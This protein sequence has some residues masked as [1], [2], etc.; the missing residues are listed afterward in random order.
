LKKY[1]SSYWI[2]SAF[3]TFLQRFSL[4]LFGFV[5]FLILIRSLSKPQMGVW[6]FFLVVTTLFEST[7]SNLLKNAHIKFVGNS[8]REKTAIASSS[9]LVN[10]T[11][12]LL[13]ICFLFL[14]SGYL[15]N[16]LHTGKEL[17]DMLRWFTPGMIALVY[18][19]HFEA[20]A[21]SHLD[22]KSVFA[23]YFARQVLFFAL[24]VGHQLLKIPFSLVHLAIYQSVSI[25]LG[26]IVLFLF[27]KKHLLYVFNPT[28]AWIKKL[29]G[30]G[31]YI[32][33]IGITSSIFSN[34]DQLMIARFTSSK[35]MVASYNAATR[36]S[37]L[38]EI[39][40][41]S[42]AEILLPKVSQVDMSEGSNKVKYMYERMVGILLCFTTPAALFIII[43]P[44]FV[45]NLIAGS[46][47]ADSSF[48]LQMYMLS[49]LVKPIQNQAANIL[50]YIGKARLCFLLNVLFVGI[51]AGLNYICFIQFGPYGAAI[52]NVIGCVLGTIV[53]YSILKK[54]IGVDF[55]N[56]WKY[57]LDTIKTI[58]EKIALLV[59][60][61]QVQ[62]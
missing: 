22:F 26:A 46:Q 48:I 4:T 20:V 9:L 55:N 54:S 14:F 8:N 6:A 13:F 61:K 15:S 19:S 5:N 33:G 57:I 30:F 3:Y 49:G 1:F 52:G 53:W 40:S 12:S 36:I 62:L 38:V 21:Q 11:I 17:E 47:Y 50:L 44:H 27:G 34:L 31:G 32:F 43:F 39:P 2:R 51:N 10:A 60:A 29:L 7:K 18:F 59:K 42:A 56:I 25:V 16:W 23:G 24:V 35:S 28:L 41:Y 45:V 58:L 37:A